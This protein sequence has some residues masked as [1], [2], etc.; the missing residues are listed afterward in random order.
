MQ[1]VRYPRAAVAVA[2]PGKPIVSIRREFD[3]QDSRTPLVLWASL[4]YRLGDGGRLVGVRRRGSQ[5]V[6]VA[7]MAPGRTAIEW[8]PAHLALTDQ[9][10]R[11]W[12]KVARFTRQ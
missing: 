9:E 10:A 8:V 5:E 2:A 7:R 1:H 4:A 6:E 11:R 12:L 3:P